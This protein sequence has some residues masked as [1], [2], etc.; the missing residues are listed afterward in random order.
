[1]TVLA[2]LGVPGAGQ[3][4]AA[5][6]EGSGYRISVDVVNRTGHAMKLQKNDL[7][8]TD[9]HGT[10]SSSWVGSALDS[11][12][13]SGRQTGAVW[14]EPGG[15]W[16]LRDIHVEYRVDG[17]DYVF[18]FKIWAKG[19]RLHGD[20]GLSWESGFAPRADRFTNSCTDLEKDGHHLALE[21]TVFSGGT[22]GR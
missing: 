9:G 2:G 11:E 5:P 21:C 17:T 12:V 16:D 15:G 4:A 7:V 22:A 18:G 3:A 1:M 6:P 19:F 10:R 13:L 14:N 20:F 8:V